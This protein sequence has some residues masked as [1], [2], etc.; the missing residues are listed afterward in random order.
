VK[1]DMRKLQLIGC[2]CG[3]PIC[4]TTYRIAGAVH[5]RDADRVLAEPWPFSGWTAPGP[6]PDVLPEW[7]PVDRAAE[8]IDYHRNAVIGG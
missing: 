2:P 8:W 6:R 3:Q 5:V 7:W 4:A 1:T